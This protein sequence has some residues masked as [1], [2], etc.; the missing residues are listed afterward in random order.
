MNY[1]VTLYSS[2]FT[3][4]SS[5]SPINDGLYHLLLQSLYDILEL[6]HDIFQYGHQQ[7]H[8]N[9]E[10]LVYSDYG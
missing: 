3:K 6:I 7:L 9:S 10:I 8:N 2:V 4:H 1:K 5:P